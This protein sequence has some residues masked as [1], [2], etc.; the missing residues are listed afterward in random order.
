MAK[1]DATS[2]AVDTTT[3][4]VLSMEQLNELFHIDK[5]F[6]PSSITELEDY[7]QEHGGILEFKGSA[8]DVIKKDVLEGVPFHIIDMRFYEGTFGDA[9]AVMAMYEAAGETHHVVF[10][11]GSTGVYQQCKYAASRS[12]RRGGFSCPKGLRAS[13]F[14]YVEK[15]LDGNPLPDAKEIPATTYYIA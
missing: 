15:D 11:D 12:G 7:F 13:H 8:Y 5:D 2:T 9:V 6:V 1:A 3:G 4:E 14:T 10:N